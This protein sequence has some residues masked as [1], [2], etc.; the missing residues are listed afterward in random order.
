MQNSQYKDYDKITQKTQIAIIIV[1]I[2]ESG[3]SS[4]F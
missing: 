4:Y 3:F 2:I 1:M